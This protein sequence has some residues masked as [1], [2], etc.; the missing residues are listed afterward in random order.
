MPFLVKLFSLAKMNVREFISNSPEILSVLPPE[1]KLPDFSTQKF[2]GI[3]W[4][5]KSDELIFP[6][7]PHPF[8][9]DS[10]FSKAD[11]LSFIASHFDPLGLLSP[12]ILPLRLFFQ[13]L[14]SLKLKWTDHLTIE[15]SEKWIQILKDW[16]FNHIISIL[17]CPSLLPFKNRIYELHCF[18]DSSLV[19]I[20][21][22][23]YLRISHPDST[24][25]NVSLFF[26]KTKVKPISRK[27]KE[28]TI[29]KLELIG[30]QLGCKAL[31]FVFK[32]ISQS[33]SPFVDRF[34][35]RTFLVTFVSPKSERFYFQPFE[36]YTFYA[37]TYHS[38]CMRR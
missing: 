29:H 7:C 1:R 11:I 32:Q 17:R 14:W 22:A 5:T 2:L 3:G 23:V 27:G 15:T 12:I 9:L 10:P 33:K 37:K 35:G 4:N 36:N 18:T 25:S 19:A 28:L 16:N 30:V 13:S 8:T 21:V 26:A 6:I 24:I 20:C 31:Q 34:F 38:P